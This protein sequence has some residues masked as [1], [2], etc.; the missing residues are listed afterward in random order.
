M[1]TLL[2]APDPLRFDIRQRPSTVSMKCAILNE[3][4]QTNL[5]PVSFSQ[6]AAFGEAYLCYYANQCGTAL[7]RNMSAFNLL[8]PTH[9]DIVDI[10][11]LIRDS[12]LRR[13]NISHTLQVKLS[14]RSSQQFIDREK[15]V[16][17]AIDLAVRLWLL[18]DIG[19][20]RHCFVPGQIPLRWESGLLK[21][22]LH[23]EFN[24][25]TILN[26]ERVKLDPLFSAR[27]LERLA[28]LKISW[29]SNLADH[30]R[31][32]DDDT[33]VALFH[34]ASALRHHA[35]SC[36]FPERFVQET[37]DTLA[38]LLPEYKKE[39]RRWFRTQQTKWPIL[40]ADATKCGQ[41]YTEKRQ[42]ENFT[43]WH[44][45]LVILKQVFDE[46]EPNTIAQW[47][48][49]RRRKVQWY[50]F[51]VAVLLLA[52]TVFF[53]LVQSIEGALQVYTAFRG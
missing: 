47:W 26:P 6:N 11:D 7:A 45:R 31:L 20:M 28:G 2:K 33:K 51:W 37:L 14:N 38:L 27:N 3:L 21:D 17:E 25:P 30:L 43:F 5:T 13:E 34:H 15:S 35:N 44:D 46:A 39:T 16:C 42:I 52:L 36:F 23:Q 19:D 49:D 32:M 50:T 41:L 18:I 9:R 29:T 24:R 22:L 10:I 53:G 8:I 4:W 40:D 1:A 12:T 48:N